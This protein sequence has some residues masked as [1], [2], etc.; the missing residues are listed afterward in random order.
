MKIVKE[1]L[2]LHQNKKTMKKGEEGYDINESAILYKGHL[3]DYIK[4]DGKKPIKAG[5]EGLL[6]DEGVHIPWERIEALIKIYKK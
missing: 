4:V 5:K 3:Y 6:G 2:S 1:K